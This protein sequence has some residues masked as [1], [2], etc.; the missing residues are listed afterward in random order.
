MPVNRENMQSSESSLYATPLAQ[1]SVTESFSARPSEADIARA[2][3][4]RSTRTPHGTH[5]SGAR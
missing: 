2:A 5:C 4:R 1:S 3:Q